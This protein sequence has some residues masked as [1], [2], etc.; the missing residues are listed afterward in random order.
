M[1]QSWARVL[2]IGVLREGAGR[3]RRCFSSAFVPL[4]SWS[5]VF[6]SAVFCSLGSFCGHGAYAHQRRSNGQY[7]LLHCMRTCTA[8]MRSGCV[9]PVFSLC[10][11]M[12]HAIV[13]AG[14]LP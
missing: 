7:I 4:V 8:Y 11:D 1:L 14:S 9:C 2:T 12:L 13:L 5:S 6:A 3:T 10:A